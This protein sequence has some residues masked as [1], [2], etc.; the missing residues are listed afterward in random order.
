MEVAER[1]AHLI[2]TRGLR[3]SMINEEEVAAMR[4][5]AEIIETMNLQTPAPS[6]VQPTL[7]N[8]ITEEEAAAYEGQLVLVPAET[9]EEETFRPE[10]PATPVT[11]EAEESTPFKIVDIILDSDFKTDKRLGKK[12]Q[13]EFIVKW[14]GY[15]LAQRGVTMD[16]I[17]PELNKKAIVDY[18]EQALP[19]EEI[20]FKE[21]RKCSK[22]KR[23]S[24]ISRA[25]NWVAK[26]YRE[27]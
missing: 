2:V 12:G 18:L 11:P 23:T 20:K 8:E 15:G 25:E 21:L 22:R 6:P 26:A 10:P 17:D 27:D 19:Y 4:E 3:H 14:K 5:T 7:A 1:Y 9:E 24:I 13:L 16:K